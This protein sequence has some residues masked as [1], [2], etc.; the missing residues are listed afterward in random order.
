VDLFIESGFEGTSVEA[1]ATR[2]SVGKATIYRRWPSKEALI[3]DA[4]AGVTEDIPVPDAGSVR[5][6][7]A[8][9]IESFQRAAAAT[10]AGRCMG[11]MMAEAASHPDLWAAYHA[12]VIEPRRTVTRGI[13]QRGIDRGEVRGDID[14]ELAIDMITGPIVYRKVMAPR[15]TW[16]PDVPLRLVDTLLRGLAARPPEV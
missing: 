2:A 8:E 13:I 1:V 7:F 6:D 16:T 9:M 10:Q 11:R 5:A 14:I 15:E 3:V 4:L 12:N